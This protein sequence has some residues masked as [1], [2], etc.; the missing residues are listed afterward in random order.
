MKR[1]V[2]LH[3][4]V[5]LFRKMSAFDELGV[6][7]NQLDFMIPISNISP[8]YRFK[9]PVSDHINQRRSMPIV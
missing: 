5:F 2:P 6:S 7:E 4:L 3:V 1:F 8:V 9:R